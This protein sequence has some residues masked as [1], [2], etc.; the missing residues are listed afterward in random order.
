MVGSALVRAAGAAGW[1]DVVMASRREVDLTR[2][3][4]VEAFFERVRPGVVIMA[5]AR[6]GGIVA[7]RDFPAA[8]FLRV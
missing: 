7:N 8:F 5:A 6:V 2:Q 4:E 3:A 1:D